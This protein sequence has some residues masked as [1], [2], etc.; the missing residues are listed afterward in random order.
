VHIPPHDR[1]THESEWRTFVADHAFGHLVAAGTDRDVPVVVP[2]QFVLEGDEVLLHLAAPNPVF[3]ALDEQPRV[4]L[5]IAGDWAFIPS[6][7]KAIGD[8]D[9]T[10]GIPTTYYAAVQL[11]GMATVEREP[12]AVARVL[13]RQLSVLQPEVTIA[14]PE[15]AHAA[16]LRAI[17]SVTI[18]VDE[19]RTKFKFGGNVDRDHRRAVID[20]LRTRGGVGDLAA[21]D[22]TAARTGD[23]PPDQRA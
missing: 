8:E 14:D 6:A 15:L 12:A 9:P 16:K 18:A 23:R 3:D 7:W 1:S 5:S 19:V 13:R 4:V 22:H 21:A 11:V 10:L 20:R 2:T 17:R